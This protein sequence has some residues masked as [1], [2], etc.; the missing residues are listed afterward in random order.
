MP[1]KSNCD[2]AIWGTLDINPKLLPY[3]S[4][5][6]QLPPAANVSSALTQTLT[7]PILSSLHLSVCTCVYICV[8]VDLCAGTHKCSYTWRPEVG[9]RCLL[10]SFSTFFFE[11]WTLVEP[12]AHRLNQ[13]GLPLSPT[14]LLS[15]CWNKRYT[16]Q[17]PACYIG[18]V[19]QT[20][21]SRV[22]SDHFTYWVISS[23]LLALILF[24]QYPVMASNSF[25]LSKND[26][27]CGGFLA[28]TFHTLLWLWQK[29][30]SLTFQPEGPKW[31]YQPTQT[32]LNNRPNIP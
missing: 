26:K 27:F 25:F 23:T 8:C 10:W 30:F 7:G 12:G 31:W 17:H 1:W 22:G 6:I 18:T 11:T 4:I 15:Q 32:G 24:S 20:Q 2:C 3:A 5:N 14:S 19:D 28:L 13:A 21:S 16:S 9:I 29:D